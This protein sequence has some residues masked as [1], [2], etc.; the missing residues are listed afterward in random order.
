M[1]ADWCSENLITLLNSQVMALRTFQ[2]CRYS[3]DRDDLTFSVDCNVFKVLFI[4]VFMLLLWGMNGKC[5]HVGLRSA[6]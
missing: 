6:G 3:P 1:I 2:G 5:L 4:K